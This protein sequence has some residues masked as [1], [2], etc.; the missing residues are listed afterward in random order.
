MHLTAAGQGWWPQAAASSSGIEA[1]DES[2]ARAEARA[3]PIIA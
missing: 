3:P 1:P 2:L